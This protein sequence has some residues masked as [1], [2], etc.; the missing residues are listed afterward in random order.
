[1]CKEDDEI[2]QEREKDK[3]QN[4][5]IRFLLFYKSR[6]FFLDIISII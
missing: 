2:D 6:F 1:M 3:G 4:C 5:T